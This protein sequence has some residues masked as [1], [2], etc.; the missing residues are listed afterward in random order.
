MHWNWNVFHSH[1]SLFRSASPLL[2]RPP[3]YKLS[4]KATCVAKTWQGLK[5]QEWFW[6]ELSCAVVPIRDRF[7]LG[8]EIWFPLRPEWK[9][10]PIWRAGRLAHSHFFPIFLLVEREWRWKNC[11]DERF[12]KRI[13]TP[14]PLR[15]LQWMVHLHLIRQGKCVV[16]YQSKCTSWM[17]WRHNSG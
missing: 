6:D 17:D 1:T 14:Q 15:V 5:L 4:T 9:V 10:W 8:H 7:H 3:I 13:S 12:G 11:E 16:Q 2:P